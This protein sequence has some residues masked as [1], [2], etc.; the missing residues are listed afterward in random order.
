MLRYTGHG[1]ERE[2]Q[3]D[4]EQQLKDFER[5]VADGRYEMK[6][7]FRRDPLAWIRRKIKEHDEFRYENLWVALY[8]L[9]IWGFISWL[10]YYESVLSLVD[11]IGINKTPLEIH[12]P[13]SL[14]YVHIPGK[15]SHDYL[16]I[17]KGEQVWCS[18]CLG[19][20]DSYCQ[21]STKALEFSQDYTLKYAVR[22]RNRKRDSRGVVASIVQRKD[23]QERIIFSNQSMYYFYN[24]LY[25]F[26]VFFFFPLLIYSLR[27]VYSALR[28]LM[29]ILQKTKQKE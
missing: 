26:C 17:S 27:N 3:K 19:M 25:Y 7:D 2:K 9:L 15:I 13:F 21:R 5:M 12:G 16:Y 24:A 14:D 6:L 23:G 11:T 29:H 10:I 8:G 20:H 22:Y 18:I 28:R 4:I 1:I